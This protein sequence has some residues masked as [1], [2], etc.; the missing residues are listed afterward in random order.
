MPYSTQRRASPSH[1]TS[2]S[3]SDF[4][5]P[6]GSVIGQNVN[7]DSGHIDQGAVDIDALAAAVVDRLA[8]DP[9]ALRHMV[10]M[11]EECLTMKDVCQRLGVAKAETVRAA[12]ESGEIYLPMF[13]VGGRWRITRRA[14]RKAAERGFKPPKRAG[15]KITTP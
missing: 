15:R 14:F 3:T 1:S 6:T 4:P 13:K 11:E 9:R 10:E 8:D 7:T 12:I 2:E 5:V